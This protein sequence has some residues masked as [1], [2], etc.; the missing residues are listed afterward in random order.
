MLLKPTAVRV[1]RR[2]TTVVEV[3]L[4]MSI[5]LLFL[6][7]LLEYARYM[8]TLHVTTNAARDA[9]RYASVRV[10]ANPALTAT[11][12][13]TNDPLFASTSIYSTNYKAYDVPDITDYLKSRM[14]PRYGTG[15]YTYYADQLITGMK[16]RVFP[17]HIYDVADT[18]GLYD[19]PPVVKPKYK[20]TGWN[21][22]GFSERIAVRVTGTYVPI[23]PS[24]LW[25]GNTA[26][27]EVDT[28]MGS[29]G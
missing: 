23:L 19:D 16:V 24:F 2:G 22:A 14:G 10:N 8:F 3:A 9:A 13:T 12:V 5:F 17:C 21:N 25:M 18:V 29:E 20:N 7:G 6:F 11:A 28:V 4:L 26:T 27:I 1:R 15:P